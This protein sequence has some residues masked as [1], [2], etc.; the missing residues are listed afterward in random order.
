MGLD[1]SRFNTTRTNILSRLNRDT[2]MTLDHVY[3]EVVA[4]ER[5][6]LVARSKEERIEAVGFAIKAGPCT[7]CG[8]T[9]HSVDTCFELHGLPDWWIEKHGSPRGS[10]R[11]ET[12]RGRGRGSN[13]GRG[14]GNNSYRANNSQ[15][16][17]DDEFSDLPDVSKETW[18]AIKGLLKSDQ[19]ANHGKLS[20]R[21][22]C[23]EF[24]LD[25]GASHHMT[26]DDY[27]LVDTHDIPRSIIV[28]PNGKHTFAIKEGT[29][30][31]GDHVQLNPRLLREM[32]CY[33]L[34]TDK[35]CVIHDR[36]SKMLI[37]A[38][39]ERDGDYHFCGAV[40]AN[41][42]YVKKSTKTLWHERLGH[43]STKILSSFLS[44]LDDFEHHSSDSSGFCE[45]CIQAKQTRS[46]FPESTDKA[47]ECWRVYDLE[48]QDFFVSRDVIFSE[49]KFPFSQEQ[50]SASLLAPPVVLPLL[51]SEDDSLD[52]V[53]HAE[54]LDRGSYSPVVVISD[55]ASDD[56]SVD[57]FTNSDTPLPVTADGFDI[58]TEPLGK[59]HR[60]K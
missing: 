21:R 60:K 31:L 54:I 29:M 2:N 55:D 1:A 19:S 35:F 16:T 41:V 30:L 46:V 10:S 4:E 9:N 53:P 42:N 50:Q 45:V 17:F 59:G 52:Q 23:V 48:K 34:F 8:R 56:V 49:E 44:T 26:G 3:S 39:K 14:R 27:L 37:G 25:S 58:G 47:D 7:H 6:L 13:R 22:S 24:L 43:P 51:N 38:G 5:H 32:S 40:L 11:I 36:T 28:L 18:A 20:G 15:V 12:T 33:A 57:D